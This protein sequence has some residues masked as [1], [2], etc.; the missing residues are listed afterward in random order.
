VKSISF[1]DGLVDFGAT[2]IVVVGMGKVELIGHGLLR[3]TFHDEHVRADGE[4][5]RPI[6]AYVVWPI[7]RFLENHL[8]FME[9]AAWA[10]AE[11]AAPTRS[12]PAARRY[13]SH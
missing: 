6:K 3:V 1:V 4:I 12:A 2:E 13:G 10:E 11:L 5:E 9:V 8:R 7:E